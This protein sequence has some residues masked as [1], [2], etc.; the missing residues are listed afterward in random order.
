MKAAFL[1]PAV[2]VAVAA[3]FCLAVPF[4]DLSSA[5]VD[6]DQGEV[7]YYTY[8]VDFQFQGT[9]AQ[10]ILWDF[11]F[12]DGNGNPVT[13][14]QWN[15][16]GIVFPA[17]GTYIVTQT[18][19]N[20]VGTYVSQLRINI[21][22][23]PEITFESNGGSDVPAQI[24]KVGSKLVQPDDPVREGYT[25]SGWYK[26]SSLLNQYN[27]GQPVTRHMTLYAKWTPVS[28]GVQPD[29]TEPQVPDEDGE[30]G[31]DEGSSA[32]AIAVNIG[33]L[34]LGAVAAF[35]GFRQGNRGI[36]IVGAVF[37]VAG[38]VCLAAGFDL[39]GLLGGGSS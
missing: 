14:D 19:G 1:I 10:W 34:A 12:D 26:E 21:M 11:G 17:K 16:S 7:T 22:G 24:V 28:P 33:L 27:F 8:T 20:T 18:V 39:I 35:F 30:E 29:D 23:T 37:A 6:N 3:M 9:D 38:I 36:V 13:S 25:F 5:E 2:A 15:P 4:A 32:P 31:S